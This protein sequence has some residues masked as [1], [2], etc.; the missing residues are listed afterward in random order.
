M[1]LQRN[2]YLKFIICGVF[3]LCLVSISKPAFAANYISAQRIATD[4]GFTEYATDMERQWYLAQIRI[5]DSWNRSV[6]STAITIAILDTGVD[7]THEDLKDAN[8]LSGYNFL[9]NR[10]ILKGENSDDNGHG[11]LVAGVIAAVPNNQIGIA[12]A[13]WNTSILPVKVLNSNGEGTAEDLAKGIIWAT[14]KGAK[15]INLSLGGTGFAKAVDLTNAVTYAFKHDVVLV[16][17]AGNDLAASGINMDE[18]PVYPIC[19]DNGQNMVIGVAALDEQNRKTE[20]SNYGKNC[21]DVSAPGQRILSTIGRD[22]VTRAPLPDRYAFASGTS[23]AAPLVSAQA[24]LLRAVYPFASN[25]QIRDRIIASA[26]PIDQYN[27]AQC[28]GGSCA[29]M[30][31]GGRIDVFASQASYIGPETFYEGDLVEETETGKIFLIS[32]GKKQEVIPYVQKQRFQNVFAKPTRTSQLVN[33]PTGPLAFPLDGSLVKATNNPTVYLVS[34]GLKLPI[35]YSV[36]Q[37]RGL[38]FTNVETLQENEI[39]SWLE[40]QLLPPAEGSLVK[41][42]TSKLVYWV[43]GQALHPINYGF[44]TSRGLSAFPVTVYSDAEIKAFP[45][46]EAYVR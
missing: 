45:K 29:N 5:P 1:N 3:L 33:I 21:V 17:A 8:I 31:G 20:F 15:V 41:S 28:S 35:S 19:E 13:V 44:Y 23:L 9:E 30:L 26:V 38:S 10:Q 18:N 22:P 36:F 46:G 25:R 16:A 12:G 27:Q 7:A 37:S 40:G 11:T 4:P 24:A 6:G 14:D 39:A 42:P 32:G 34:K 2:K 43:V